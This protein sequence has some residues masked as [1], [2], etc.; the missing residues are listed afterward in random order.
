MRTQRSRWALATLVGTLVL[1]GLAFLL[2]WYEFKQSPGA[3]TAPESGSNRTA[4]PEEQ[5][6]G[7]FQLR[8]DVSDEDRQAGQKRVEI[9]GW[10]WAAALVVT[11]V[12]AGLEVGLGTFEGS[13]WPLMTTAV[14]GFAATGLG[15][16]WTYF[17]MPEA[18]V[19]EG[20]NQTFTHFRADGDVVRTTVGWGFIAAGLSLIGSLAYVGFKFATGLH[21]PAAVE[22]FTREE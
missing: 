3:P 14:L 17:H 7:P 13:R 1:L 20:V 2:P 11:F 6:Y 9:L 16:W 4:D 5:T 8:G 12:T 19:H 10:F 21:D 18:L 15:L 22:E